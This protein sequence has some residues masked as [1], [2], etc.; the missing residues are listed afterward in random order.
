MDNVQNC[1]SSSTRSFEI[2]KQ[3]VIL[4]RNIHLLSLNKTR[5]T[6]RKTS[7]EIILYE[8]IGCCRNL[9]TEGIQAQT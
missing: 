6:Y 2:I 7:P 3:Q 4:D 9:L 8:Y 5:T 1:D